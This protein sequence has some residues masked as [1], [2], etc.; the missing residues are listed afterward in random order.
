MSEIVAFIAR[1]NPERAQTFG[2]TLLAKAFQLETQPMMG[3]VV[4]EKQDPEVREIVY[5]SYRIIYRLLKNPQRVFVV[6]FWHGA[7][8]APQIVED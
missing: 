5:R 8:G 1:N 4:A 2:D 6:R 3:R 7:R